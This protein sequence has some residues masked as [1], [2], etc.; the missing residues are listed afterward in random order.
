MFFHMKLVFSPFRLFTCETMGANLRPVGC[1]TS[2]WTQPAEA[3]EPQQEM[4]RLAQVLRRS[5]LFL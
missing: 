1:H 5:H 2:L 4:L 3:M